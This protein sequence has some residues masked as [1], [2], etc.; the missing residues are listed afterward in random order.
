MEICIL[1]FRLFSSFSLVILMPKFYS[2]DLR[3]RIV[4]S[5]H[6]GVPVE[7]L[8][9]QYSVSRSSVYS[10]LKQFRETG[11]AAPKTYHPGRKKKLAPY[12]TEVRKIIAEHP[13]GTLADFCDKLSPTVVVSTTTLCDYLRCLKMTRKKRPSLP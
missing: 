3:E 12:E 6:S 7:D 2:V 9:V 10:Y 1:C 5:Y 8:V 4:N 13:D 11:T